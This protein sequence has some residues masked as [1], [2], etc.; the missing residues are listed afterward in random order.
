MRRRRRSCH[1]P[2]MLRL[3]VL[4][5]LTLATGAL[6]Q[7]VDWPHYLGGLDSRQFADLDEIT[8]QNVASLE[9]AWIYRSGD[10]DPANRSQIQC[11]PLVIDGVLYATTPS[12]HAVAL[13]AAI[14]RE[15]W[16]FNPFEDGYK[17]FGLG[18]NRGLAYW[19][20]GSERRLFYSAGSSLYALDAGTGELFTPFGDAGVVDLRERLSRDAS[21]LFV[22]AN[23][24]GVVFEDLLIVGTRVAEGHPAAPGDIRA[25]DVHS[26]AIRWTFHTI[27]RPG[28]FGSETWPGDAWETIGGAN[29]WAGMSLDPER[30]TV[31]IPTG[32]PAYDFYGADRIGD[33]LF[34][35]CLLALDAR[36]GERKWHFQFVRHDLWDRDIPAPPN[37]LTIEHD[38]KSVAA[39]AQ[40]TKSG[41]VFV[42]DRETGEPLFPIDEIAV[43][44]SELPGETASLTQPLPQKPPAF[45]RQRFTEA[46]VT[47]RTPEAHD[48]ILQQLR[49]LHSEGQFYPPSRRGTVILPGYDGGGEWGGAAHDPRTGILYVN[50]SE[51]AWIL[52]MF[53]VSSEAGARQA[54]A[55]RLYAENCLSCHGVAREGDPLG[56]Y[57][58]LIGLG[59]KYTKDQIGQ[60]IS[61]GKGFMPSFGHLSRGAISV[62]SDYLLE[63]PASIEAA[64]EDA[65]DL[66]FVH[67]GYTRFLDKDGYPALKPPWGTL[68]SIDL[69]EGTLLWQVPLGD[70]PE[71]REPGDP[72]TGTENYGG[73]L[74]TSSGLLFIGATSDEKFRAFDA[75]D[76]QLLWETDL[77]AAGYATPASYMVDGRQFVVIAA[78]GGKIGTPS[79]DAWVAFALPESVGAP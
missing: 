25:Y 70:R 47:N 8:P 15:I 38:G 58:A 24:P 64:E 75:N 34:A 33:N 17:L 26:G 23:S 71:A 56:A 14:G 59:E 55:T 1:D 16:R 5:L 20:D 78:G 31:Y 73:P 52:R 10:A 21:R 32:S 40:I 68:S 30:G 60:I 49:R 4:L 72:P 9:T 65:R 29:A 7:T 48:D 41:H 18:V 57:P 2:R 13:D 69:N 36:T 11:N 43:P 44:P 76:G 63:P 62:L 19:S 66:S 53:P 79:G 77:P 51:M 46:D 28:E 54:T 35:N 61:G 6:G 27:P 45:S 39:V 50:A 42:F 37:L 22:V 74:L 12:L 3:T 67:T